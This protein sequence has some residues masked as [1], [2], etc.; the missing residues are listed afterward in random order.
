M[1]KKTITIIIIL[2]F[3]ISNGQ[4]SE[5]NNIPG[6]AIA[7]FEFI[8]DDLGYA[9]ANDIS[10]NK[11]VILKTINGGNNWDTIPSLNG[12]GFM[13]I[14]FISDG[15]GFVVFRDMNNSFAP[16]R[17]YKTSND[18][19][20][21]EDISPSTTNT[22][23]GNSFVQFIDEN[24]GFWG[25]ADVLYK[26][27][28]AGINWDT[29][30]FSNAYVSSLDFKDANNGT[31]GTWDG[32][33]FYGGGM[34]T[35]ND[36]GNTFNVF[37]LNNYNSVINS[38]NYTT[39]NTIYT[40]SVS[41]YMPNGYSPCLYKSIDNGSSWDSISIDTFNIPNATLRAVDF[42]DDVNGKIILSEQFNDTAYVYNTNDGALNWSFGDTIIMNNITDLT[43]TQNSA[44]ICGDENK[45][46]KLNNISNSIEINEKTDVLIFP[47]PVSI[48]ETLIINS[49]YHFQ[50]AEIFNINGKL[51][52]SI[53][54]HSNKLKI[55]NV[56]SGV[57]YLKLSN[58][59]HY[60]T[61]P[62]YVK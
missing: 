12:D 13:D 26:T 14:S 60:F 16:M 36:G 15:V 5:L 7:K 54:M 51:I 33:F 32:S 43:I 8:D 53:I 24:I 40:A 23:M 20:N 25:V 4:W 48:N 10:L 39:N 1:L 3:K 35:T 37:T 47:N 58:E 41:N 2:I 11:N 38:V 30:V 42:I 19:I 29:I 17:I 46:F 21:W 45:I 56:P 28:D 55:T 61:K 62:F 44:Y 22:G 18:G 59:N 50:F 49:S 9:L 27:I 6:K 31:I 52:K 57:Y 34:Q